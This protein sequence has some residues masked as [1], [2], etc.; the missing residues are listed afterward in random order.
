MTTHIP[1]TAIALIALTAC[2]TEHAPHGVP[3]VDRPSSRIIQP[4][5]QGV[6]LLDFEPKTGV[7]MTEVTLDLS[8]DVS[9]CL[10]EGRCA[11]AVGGQTAELVADDQGLRIL[12]PRNVA[13][14]EVCA[15]IDGAES[16]LSG[17]ELLERP[18]VTAAT[19][20]QLRCS[21][22]VVV[23]GEGFPADAEVAIDG[24]R[25]AAVVHSSTSLELRLDSNALSTGEH[26]LEVYAPSH[27]RCGTPSETVTFSVR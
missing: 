23:E 4:G 26:A 3:A 2:G 14:G 24:Q 7:T 20:E 13:G 21:A 18:I 22:S 9:G 6:R 10:A 12:I 5:Q 8:H 15:I 19:G 16:C 11:V 27:G 25:F 1:A 17:F